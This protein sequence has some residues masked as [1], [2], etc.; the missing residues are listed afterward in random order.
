MTIASA[1]AIIDARQAVIAMYDVLRPWRR[2]HL[3]LRELIEGP[4]EMALAALHIA[5]HAST[6]PEALGCVLPRPSEDGTGPAASGT[7]HD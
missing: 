1:Q 3:V 4:Y 7:D 2:S 5:L 6:T